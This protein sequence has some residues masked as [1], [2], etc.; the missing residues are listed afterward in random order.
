MSLRTKK[1]QYNNNNNK[2]RYSNE[3]ASK[4]RSNGSKN[5]KQNID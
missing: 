5:N 4:P 1:N 3:K 2:P